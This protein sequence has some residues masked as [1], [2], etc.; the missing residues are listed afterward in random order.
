MAF[1]PFRANFEGFMQ[2]MDARNQWADEQHETALAYLEG[3][4][5]ALAYLDRPVIRR[6][7]FER[8]SREFPGESWR[9]VRDTVST[10]VSQLVELGNHIHDEELRVFARW[11]AP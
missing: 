8:I 7:T 5:R 10:I 4:V 6:L 9:F 1:T 11:Y 2:E 3:D